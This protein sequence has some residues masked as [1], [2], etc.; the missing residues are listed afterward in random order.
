MKSLFPLLVCTS[1]LASFAHAQPIAQQAGWHY[2]LS[3]NSA[4][5]SGESNLSMSDENEMIDNLYSD[6]SSTSDVIIFPFAEV[7]YLSRD[8]KTQFFLGG[9]KD[10]ISFTPF[11]YELGFTHQFEN[12]SKLTLAYSPQLPLFDE[13]WQD[14]YLVGQSRVKTDIDTQGVRFELSRIAGGPITLKY[15]FASMDIEN[16]QSGDSWSENELSLTQQEQQSLQRS[17]QF[18]R[19]AIETMF[20]VFINQDSK[21]FLK[22]AIQYTAQLADGEAISNDEYDLQL[23]MLIFKGQ[24]TFIT[25]VNIGKTLFKQ[26]NPIFNMKQDSLNTGISSVYS[27]AE[28]FNFK[29]LTFTLVTA[30]SQKNSQITFFDESGFIVSTGLSYAF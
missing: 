16:D 21:V 27:Y 15:A 23:G 1:L 11:A 17:S 28:V 6:A 19:V 25:K 30:Y 18:H 20:P 3:L 5:V 14:P 24:H 13:V 8:L 9:S 12:N 26:E 4:Y 22:P 10:H 29:A 2:S 7:Q